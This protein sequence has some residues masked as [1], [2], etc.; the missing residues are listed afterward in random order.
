MMR[1]EGE[2]TRA[3]EQIK[4]MRDTLDSVE[5]LLKSADSVGFDTPQSVLISAGVLA[6]TL[7]RLDAYQRARK[8]LKD[9]QEDL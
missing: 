3:H 5:A 2:I 8:D 6:A 9:A 7:S 1:I 4:R